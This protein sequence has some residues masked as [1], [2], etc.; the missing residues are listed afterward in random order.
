MWLFI[1]ISDLFYV[2]NSQTK[3]CYNACMCIQVSFR[4]FA[5]DAAW[6]QMTLTLIIGCS[7]VERKQ[8]KPP[9]SAASGKTYCNNLIMGLYWINDSP[10]CWVASFQQ[11]LLS[12]LNG[13][14]KY[15]FKTIRKADL[16]WLAHVFECQIFTPLIPIITHY[17][18]LECFSFES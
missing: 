4:V 16:Y 13:Q 8:K 5:T 14:V 17:A 2:F 7:R 6:R 18:L 1:C 10:L 3:A 15:F 9:V 12:L 11:D